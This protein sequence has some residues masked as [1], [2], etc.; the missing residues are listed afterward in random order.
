MISFLAILFLFTIVF[1]FLSFFSLFLFFEPPC[2]PSHPVGILFTLFPLFYTSSSRIYT[3][4]RMTISHT[5]L[6]LMH[7]HINAH[8]RRSSFNIIPAPC[9]LIFTRLLHEITTLRFLLLPSPLPSSSE[10][11]LFPNSREFVRKV[12]SGAT[13]PI[14]RIIKRVSVGH[15]SFVSEI[16]EGKGFEDAV[17]CKRH[18]NSF[19]LVARFSI[20][21][22]RIS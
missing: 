7:A 20:L 22:S 13:E 19:R 15:W 8:W 2:F 21:F 4:L 3:R 1:A 6:M 14:S 11:F 5:R 18:N 10:I 17:V 16:R 9:D 12:A